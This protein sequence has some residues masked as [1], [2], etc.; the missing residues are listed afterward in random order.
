MDRHT[1][2]HMHAHTYILIDT[3]SE[4]SLHCFVTYDN[5]Q[6]TSVAPT[7]CG[8]PWHQ[9]PQQVWIQGQLSVHSSGQVAVLAHVLQSPDARAGLLALQGMKLSRS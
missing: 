7:V 5:S 2:A 6:Q 9:E 8:A 4:G 3:F 1:H